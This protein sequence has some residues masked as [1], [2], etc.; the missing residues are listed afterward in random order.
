MKIGKKIDLIG[1]C[2]IINPTFRLII[3]ALSFMVKPIHCQSFKY[4]Q[5]KYPRV[6][7]AYNENY[8]YI[9]AKLFI[10]SLARAQ[11][12]RRLFK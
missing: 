3:I 5:L 8:D 9:A 11:S 12:F 1:A 2:T 7:A 10:I 4:D 6:R